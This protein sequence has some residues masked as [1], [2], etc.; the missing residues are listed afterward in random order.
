MLEKLERVKKKKN[1]KSQERDIQKW[2]VEMPEYRK[3]FGTIW[4]L[5]TLH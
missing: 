1:Y 3:Y 5:S 4:L 2:L